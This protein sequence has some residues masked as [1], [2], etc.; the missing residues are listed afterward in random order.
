M[1]EIQFLKSKGLI[2]EGFTEFVISGDFGEVELTE[3][4]KEYKAEQLRLHGIVNPLIESAPPDMIEALESVLTELEAL[5]RYGTDISTITI[6]K[7][8][9]ALNKAKGN[10]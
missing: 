10:P 9:K 4:L 8:Q 6:A 3:L 1:S 2:K 7:V 5:P